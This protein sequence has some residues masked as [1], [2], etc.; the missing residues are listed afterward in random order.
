MYSFDGIK[1]PDNI[2]DTSKLDYKNTIQNNIFICEICG[3]YVNDSNVYKNIHEDYLICKNCYCNLR[4]PCMCRICGEDFES[5]N[6]LFRHLE[7]TDHYCDPLQYNFKNGNIVQFVCKRD[8]DIF[9]SP[10]GVNTQY[11]DYNN[12]DYKS[13]FNSTFYKRSDLESKF[14]IVSQHS[15]IVI[16]NLNSIDKYI[17]DN[18]WNISLNSNEHNILYDVNKNIGWIN[19]RHNFIIPISSIIL[20][21]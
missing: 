12:I 3:I 19:F 18:F 14:C 15:S 5:R 4:T 13:I 17:L 6:E 21:L 9:I 7:E 20:I 16:P 10:D 11:G 1:N 2:N 8:Y